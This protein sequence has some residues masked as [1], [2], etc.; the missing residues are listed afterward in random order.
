MAEN[1]NTVEMHGCIVCGRVFD[2]LV[3][4]TPE[5]RMVDC[6]VISPGGHRLANEERPLVACDT[7]TDEDISKAYLKWQ[8]RV[9][10]E[11]DDE[12]EDE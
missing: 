6:E 1:R 12:R 7:H 9:I 4:Y 5:D 3:I 11:L 2:V 10:E 8:S